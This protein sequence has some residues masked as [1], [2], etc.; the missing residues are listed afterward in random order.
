MKAWLSNFYRGYIQ[1]AMGFV[2]MGFGL[3]EYIDMNTVNLI[4]TTLGPKWGPIVSK[5]IQISAGIMTA[6]RAIQVRRRGP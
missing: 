6:Y 3:L 5:G 2:E 1:T 4:G